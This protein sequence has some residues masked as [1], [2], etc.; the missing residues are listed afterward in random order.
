MPQP[1][2][3]LLH[4]GSANSRPAIFQLLHQEAIDISVRTIERILAEE[5]FKKLP[6]RTQLVS[7]HKS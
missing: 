2:R 1:G 6:R 3:K 4:G 5:G 7:V